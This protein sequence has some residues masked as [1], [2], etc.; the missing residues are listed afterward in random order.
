MKGFGKNLKE[1][2]FQK[3]TFKK[4]KIIVQRFSQRFC[5]SI[6]SESFSVNPILS[7]RKKIELFFFVKKRRNFG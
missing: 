3:E 2:N 1:E 5:N 4:F 7:S 6:K